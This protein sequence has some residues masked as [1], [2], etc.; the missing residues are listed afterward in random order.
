LFLG[1]ASAAFAVE[2][3]AAESIGEV[4]ASAG[5]P[6]AEGPGGSRSLGA[7]SQVFQDDRIT[8]QSNANAQIMFVDGTRLVVGPRSTVV[9]DEFLL[10][11]P[12]R[13]K[14]VSLDALRGTFRFITGRSAKSAFKI[15]T[16]N[17]TIGIRGTGFDFSSR[18]NTTLA[19]HEGSTELCA[20]GGS[21]VNVDSGCEVGRAGGNSSELL[22]GSSKSL[23]IQNNL[24]YIIDQS[25]LA[26]PFRLNVAACGTI[27]PR[28]RSGTEP[29]QRG[30][31]PTGGSGGGGADGGGDDGGGGGYNDY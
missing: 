1:A 31:N 6:T 15:Q 30:N 4:V 13:A 16:A 28:P 26:A 21:C 29:G 19:V 22:T 20:A 18:N 12:D 24:P 25:P 2:A 9:I 14:A 17:A 3:E 23:A 5:S 8:T 27:S 11:S 10:R 7:G